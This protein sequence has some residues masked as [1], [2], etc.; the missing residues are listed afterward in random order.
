[1][2]YLIFAIF[3][4]LLLVSTAVGA[5]EDKNALD[6][7][8]GD[9][10]ITGW[11]TTGD[12]VL[13]PASEAGYAIG[14]EL[15]LLLEYTPTYFA[16]Q[17]YMNHDNS[18]NMTIEIIEFPSAGDA[19]GYYQLSPIIY[20]KPHP[21]PDVTVAPY[22]LGPAPEIDTIRKSTMNIST[23]TRTGSILLLKLLKMTTRRRFLKS[24]RIFWRDCRARPHRRL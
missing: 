16:S 8:P 18:K 11:L 14:D 7:L 23:A 1:M 4:A 10:F 24:P 12:A 2:R 19:Y 9:N 15:P 3:S 17:T 20:L 21:E 5:Q 22:D 6:Y 13:I